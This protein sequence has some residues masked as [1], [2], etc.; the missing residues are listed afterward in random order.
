MQHKSWLVARNDRQKYNGE[1][2]CTLMCIC[3]LSKLGYSAL[4]TACQEGYEQIV[5]LLIQAGASVNSQQPLVLNLDNNIMFI[6]IILR[7][8]VHGL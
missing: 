3:I 6:D 8:M 7:S 2:W 1:P 5:K 4:L